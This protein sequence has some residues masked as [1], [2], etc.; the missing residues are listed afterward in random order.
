MLIYIYGQDCVCVIAP[1]ACNKPPTLQHGIGSRQGTVA[2][3]GPD[4]GNGSRL[5]EISPWMWR[6]GMG[7]PKEVSVAEAET[8]RQEQRSQAN[9]QS[10]QTLKRR[11][12]EHW[13]EF[14][15]SQHGSQAAEA[16]GQ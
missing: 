14:Y 4:T 8:K 13:D 7:Q 10:A 12:E 5:F 9:Q 16:D 6:C 3:T 15:K 11:R 1:F 2:D